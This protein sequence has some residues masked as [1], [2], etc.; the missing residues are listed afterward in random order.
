MSEQSIGDA[1]TPP[2]EPSGEL[3]VASSEPG[4]T[5][6]SP[7][8]GDASLASVVR[9]LKLIKVWLIVL[10]VI[11][12][13]VG[14]ATVYGLV[15]EDEPQEPYYGEMYEPTDQQVA[16]ALAEVEEAYGDNLESVEV[17]AVEVDLGEEM[18]GIPEGEGPPP[19]IYIEYRLK[20][21]ATPFAATL[22]DP[23]MSV[24]ASGLIPT[25]GSLVSRMSMEQ[26]E[27]LIAAYG[28]VT[29]A[30]IGG[31]RRYGDSTMMPE[32]SV[33]DK[34]K[35]GGRS[36]KTDELWSVVEGAIVEGDTVDIE[37]TAY[38]TSTVHVFHE[39]PKTGQITYLGTEPAGMWY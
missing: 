12:V 31:V 37:D 6:G 30:P 33:A 3:P 11:L 21:I 35:S 39:D 7:A 15:D 8:R 5:A 13:A 4:A 2:A 23:M 18:Q 26:L 17:V 14:A 25:R 10:T 24:S 38:A 19:T 28:D 36:Y 27:R 16:D 22:M 1:T 20:G 34:I 9:S 29:S 32:Q